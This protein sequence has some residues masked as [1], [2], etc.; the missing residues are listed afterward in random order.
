MATTTWVAPSA[1]GRLEVFCVGQNN[2]GDDT[3][4]WHLWQTAPSNGWSEWSS[5]DNPP[6]GFGGVQGTSRL[7]DSPVVAA[8]ADGRLEVFG[9]GVDLQAVY[10]GGALWHQWQTAPSNGWSDWSSFGI[11]SGVNLLGTM[12]VAA[13]ADGRLE[14]FAPGVDGAL[15][16]L[17]Q[18]APSNGWSDWS[19]FGTPP[20]VQ[21]LGVPAVAPSADGRL[22][23]FVVGEDGAVYH[24]W[25]TAPSNGWSGWSSFGA[26][27]GVGLVALSAVAASA[28][29][30]LELF[31]VGGDP[32][33]GLWHQWQTAPS[34]GWSGWSSFGPPPG[35]LLGG[36]P[37]VAPSAD[38][39]LE[40]FVVGADGALWHLWQTAPSNGWSGWSSFGE[41]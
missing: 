39:R 19:S 29:G 14:F 35:T 23:L 16:H 4:L 28:D 36:I 8:N 32:D 7:W 24:Q 37:A 30:R 13:S 33:G 15:Y 5:F 10:Q 40:V 12:A 9:V 17:W 18:T 3:A 22:E 1:D 20:G 31:V 6:P 2:A 41:R 25:Q 11:P 26:P 21:L 27:P 34:N 38:G